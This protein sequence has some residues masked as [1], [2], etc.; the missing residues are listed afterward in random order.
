MLAS[1]L[2]VADQCCAQ[3]QAPT[4]APPA[5][6]AVAAPAQNQAE[7]EAALSKLLTGATLEGSFT[8][9]GREPDRLRR[10]KYTLG[11][12]RK[13]Q[14]KTWLIEAKIQYRDMDAVMVPLPLPIEWAGDTPVIVVDNVTIPGMGTFSARVMFYDDHYIGYWKHDD[15]GGHMFGIVRPAVAANAGGAAAAQEKPAE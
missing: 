3:A 1:L 4:D 14:G 8:S 6:S 5:A 9:R 7:R 12:V 15:R 11:Q 10:D 13:L 2:A